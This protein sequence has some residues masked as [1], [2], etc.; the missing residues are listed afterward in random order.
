[1]QGMNS[2][3][4]TYFIKPLNDKLNNLLVTRNVQHNSHIGINGNL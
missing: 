3:W 2:W 4:N 1:M